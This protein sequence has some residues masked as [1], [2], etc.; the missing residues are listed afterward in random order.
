MSDK[1]TKKDMRRP[2]TDEFIDSEGKKQIRSTSVDFQ[3]L[4]FR[5]IEII[6]NLRGFQQDKKLVDLMGKAK[7]RY[8]AGWYSE[9]LDYLNKSLERMPEL[10]SYIFY[11]IR[12]CKQV[13]AVPLTEEEK[14]YEEERKHYRS[15]LKSLPR[16]L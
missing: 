13:L 10:E 15:R 6:W 14:R 2:I 5:H 1:E 4:P 9:A 7:G 8:D 16:W 12:V 11:Y 3:T